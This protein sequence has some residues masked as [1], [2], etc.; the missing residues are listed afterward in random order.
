MNHSMLQLFDA[1]SSTFTYILFDSASREAVIIDPVDTQLRRDLDVLQSHRLQLKW[2]IETHAHADHITSAAKLS[3]HTGAQTAAPEYCQI[4][5]ATIQLKDGDTLEFGAQT[6]TALHTPGHTAGSMSFVWRDAVFTGDTLLINGCGRTDFQSGSPEDM[7]HSITQRLF[8]LPATTRVFPGHDYN[9]NT[10]STIGHEK[11]HNARLAGQDLADFVALMNGLN[12][13][14][15][16]RILEAL[17]AN[18][19]LGVRHDAGAH[20]E[21]VTYAGDITPSLAFTWWQ[22]GAIL[23]DVRTDAERAW[24][25]FVPDA[26]VVAWKQWPDM[27]NNP[28]F[29][30]QLAQV[31]NC[32]QKL[33]FLCRSGVRA[34]AA[35]ERATALGYTAYNI[36][37]GFE[38]ELDAHAHRRQINGWCFDGLPWRQS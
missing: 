19:N 3:E 12:L 17:P 1:Q 11:S 37:G 10:S 30:A 7:F 15:P 26:Q 6:I 24:A 20:Q 5:G 2:V 28:D 4:R 21:S 22:N 13:P 34:V 9:G 18:L 27:S 29:D 23:I 38:G 36:E 35:A 8:A 16:K 25:G 31:A 32:T 33:L 14:N